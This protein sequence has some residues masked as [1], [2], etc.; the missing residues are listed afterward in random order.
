MAAKAKSMKKIVAK[1]PSRAKKE[2]V[3]SRDSLALRVAALERM[4]GALAA[5]AASRKALNELLRMN[6]ELTRAEAGTVMV[7]DRP[8]EMLVFDV[9]RGAAA[10][11]L[12]NFR[13]SVQ[14]GIAGWV[15]RNGKA[16]LVP[17]VSKDSRFSAKVS[18]KIRYEA[19]NMICVP[20]LS[21][22]KIIGVVQLLNHRE[23]QPFQ[24]KDLETTET[25]ASAMAPLILPLFENGLDEEV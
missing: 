8:S 1:K 20:I 2:A 16:L 15:A 3:I 9:V 6:C 13:M 11:K 10:V 12:Q 21:R 7:L 23:E 24:A 17:D 5:G 4:V 14:E 25:L 22:D 18:R 19:R